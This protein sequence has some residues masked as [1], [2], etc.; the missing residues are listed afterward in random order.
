[1]VLRN[2]LFTD[3]SH[4]ISK[5][6]IKIPGENPL[7]IP[8]RYVPKNLSRKDKKKQFLNLKKSRKLYK[9]GKYF[10]R[11]KIDSFHSKPSNH[12]ENAR[13]IYKIE[14]ISP[15]RELA[16]KTKCSQKGLEKILN[17]GRGAYFSSGSRP[18]QTGESWGRA[19]L[20]S[21]ISGGNASIVDYYILNSEC[22]PDSKALR[23]ATATCRK[24]GKCLKYTRKNNKK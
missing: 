2:I 1:M 15:S 20:A 11:P 13:K 23:M 3:L 7:N 6:L 18:N 19:R 8:Q 5:M 4:H 24:Q 21:A 22:K 14:N 10:Q 17:K 12:L 16:I 9:K